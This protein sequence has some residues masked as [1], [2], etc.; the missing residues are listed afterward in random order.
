MKKLIALL[1]ALTMVLCLS[2]CGQKAAE[3]DIFA[4]GEGVM[5]AAEYQAAA[6]DTAVTVET[7]VQAKQGWWEKDGVG[8]ASFYT[9]DKDGG[10]FLYNMPCS[11]EDYNKLVPGTKIKV[12][13]YKAEWAGEVEI[14]DSSFEILEGSYVAEPKDVT[15][16]LGTDDLVKEQNTYIAVNGLTVAPANDAGA[17]FLFNWDGSGAEGDDLYFYLT[18][19]TNTYSFT[20]ESYL[21]GP[22]TEVYK[23][24]MS[25]GVGDTVDVLGFLYWYEGSQPHVTDVIFK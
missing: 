13:G 3:T 24:V 7:F 15:A 2:A 6:V 22:D 21:C 9:Q 11:Q 4:K 19:G 12:T 20:V 18:D 14:I 5:T 25:L 16:L 8:V 17:P 1:L 23:K 10:Y